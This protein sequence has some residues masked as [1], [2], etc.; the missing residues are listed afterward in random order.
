MK[1]K[2]S[3]PMQ[4]S[5]GIYETSTTPKGSR[6]TYTYIQVSIPAERRTGERYRH[7]AFFRYGQGQASKL[8]ATKSAIKHRSY[9]MTTM[10]VKR[11]IKSV[12][13]DQVGASNAFYQGRITYRNRGVSIPGIA[14]LTYSCFV[15]NCDY[16]RHAIYMTVVH[17]ETG[18]IISKTYA[19][20]KRSVEDALEQAIRDRAAVRNVYARGLHKVPALK[21]HVTRLMVK[22]EADL[23][24][25]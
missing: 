15:D 10:D 14:G 21:R 17:P 9:L 25:A 6:K 16:I 2:R 20:G 22:R 1:K 23:M 19:I 5:W 3:V 24:A 11:Y 8:Q 18:D 13:L 4:P 12:Y 7:T